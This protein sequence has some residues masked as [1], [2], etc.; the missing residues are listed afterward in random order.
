M[1]RKAFTLI[2]L[3][4]VIAI[5]AILAAILFPVFA[6]AKEAAKKTSNLSNMKQMG[7]ACATYM[8]D[9]DDLMPRA[10]TI[11]ADNTARWNTIH[12]FPYNW[13]KG[14][15]DAWTGADVMAENAGYWANALFIYTK[16][17]GIYDGTGFPT[18]TNA[19]DAADLT[20]YNQLPQTI[21][22]TY[23]GLLHTMSS[24]EMVQP[25]KVPLFWPGFGKSGLK[26][27]ALANPSLRCDGAGDARS[28]RFNPTAP[29]M[30]GATGGYAWFWAGPAPASAYQFGRGMNFNFTDTS[31]K[32]KRL[33][34]PNAPATST[35]YYDQPFAS[36]NADT[37]PASMWGCTAA[38]G[39]ASY[40]C[41]F[42]PDNPN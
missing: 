4:V 8:A 38:G 23:N 21:T 37:T 29:P 16:N 41:F 13:K 15:G 30:T 40:S 28:C 3:L 1:T 18:A 9:V 34:D 39:T 32:F 36:I 2:E 24:S 11:R 25:S 12:P 33:Y 42:R 7:T 20:N 5:I 17:Y 10:F 19:A 31:A 6:Q 27:R 35:A 26:G 14:S 22:M